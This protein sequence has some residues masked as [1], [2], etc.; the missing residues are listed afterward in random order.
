[1]WSF[2]ILLRTLKV[3]PSHLL[4][5]IIAQTES[6]CKATCFLIVFFSLPF[7]CCSM[8]CAT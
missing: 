4:H 8:S 2:H 7:G 6:G 3:Y 1:M 5:I